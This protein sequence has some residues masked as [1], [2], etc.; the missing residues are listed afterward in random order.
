M[1]T[2][3][4]ADEILCEGVSAGMVLAEM[5]AAG[6]DPVTEFREGLYGL[7]LAVYGAQK[8]YRYLLTR[9]FAAWWLT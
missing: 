3:A 8:V 7:D 9:R 1:T 5:D 6:A 4:Y 2:M